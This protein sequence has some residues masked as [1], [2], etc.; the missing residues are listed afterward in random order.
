M[1][2]FISYKSGDFDAVEAFR[3]ELLEISPDVKISIV[4]N[5]PHWKRLTKKYLKESD[6]VLYYVGKE[7][8]DNIDWEINTTL[9]Y[10]QI[11]YPVAVDS[12]LL[13]N[14][15]LYEIDPYDQSQKVLKIHPIISKEKLIDQ[16]KGDREELKHRLF[17]VD[18]GQSTMM[19]QYKV[20]LSTSESLIERRQKI[21]TTYISIFSILLPII[22]AMLSQ[23][24]LFFYF[25]SL[26]I[27]II[28][29]ILCMSWK[30]TIISYGKSN[31]AKFAIL[32][33]MEH[34]LSVSMFASEWFA[35]RKISSK[36]VSFTKRETFVPVLFMGVYCLFAVASVVMIILNFTK[37]I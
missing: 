37:I 29:I 34:E 5:S 36:Y 32:E 14:E 22:S 26:A 30:Q 20:L 19:D 21:T 8:S 28:C 4:R 11:V 23:A 2:I 1:K 33:E 25:G 6:L 35:L 9:K 13:L 15:R 7:Y 12:T 18:K 16:I 31:A 17:N 3:K 10:G 27:S 24:N